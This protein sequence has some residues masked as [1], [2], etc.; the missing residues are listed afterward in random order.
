VADASPDSRA[1]QYPASLI[2][3]QPQSTGLM[4]ERQA[5][6]PGIFPDTLLA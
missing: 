4:H 2:N 3:D 1:L 5:K 6:P